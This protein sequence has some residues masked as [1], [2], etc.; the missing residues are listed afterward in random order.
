MEM[1]CY[2]IWLNNKLIVNSKG[3]WGYYETEDEAFE[4]AYW[5][6]LGLTDTEEYGDYETKDFNVEVYT[7]LR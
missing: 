2:E 7:V 4:E 6:V 3:L 5:D 1:Y